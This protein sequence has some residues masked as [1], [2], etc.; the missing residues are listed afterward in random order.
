[1]NLKYSSVH[2]N[3]SKVLHKTAVAFFL[4]ASRSL[5]NDCFGKSKYIL[6]PLITPL[7]TPMEQK[8]FD[9]TLYN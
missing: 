8:L 9:Y 5:K 3:E 4:T 2:I 7:S 6:A 1:M